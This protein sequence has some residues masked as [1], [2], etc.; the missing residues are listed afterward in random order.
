MSD[1][2]ILSLD[3][4]RENNT[5]LK[6]IKDYFQLSVFESNKIIDSFNL[7]I[8]A[9]KRG[10]Y[11]VAETDYVDKVYRDSYYHY[12]ATKL[13]EYHRNCIRIS[14]FCEE[15]I[16]N[17]L[18]ESNDRLNDIYRGFMVIRPL[19]D[20]PIGRTLISPLA[21]LDRDMAICSTYVNATVFGR[22]LR[23]LGFPHSSQ[24][25][26]TMTCAQVAIWSL[27]EYSGNKYSEYT[28]TLPSQIN[29]ILN[30]R[31]TI[32]QLPSVGLLLD[33][34]SIAIQKQGFGAITYS[35]DA[36]K[37]DF[38]KI[39]TCYVESGI[40][41]VVAL[42]NKDVKHAVLCIG[43]SS[44]PNT[45]FSK[46]YLD[47]VRFKEWNKNVDNF[48]FCDDN[49]PAYHK[50]LFKKPMN[51]YQSDSFANCQISHI[52]VPLYHKVYLEAHSAIKIQIAIYLQQLRLMMTQ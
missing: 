15:I 31:A 4:Q 2:F 37:E 38:K 22:K 43:R 30:F 8:S 5:L 29:K 10:L 46:T 49:L 47:G 6:I 45:K 44:K 32:R 25:T 24:D 17:T 50:A 35:Q 34:I 7:Y 9:L 3:D 28:P 19:I 33:D 48:I 52:V 12:Y 36:Y 41:I 26:E 18:F 39:F 42:E 14:F 51:G 27:M 40:P 23:V 20:S 16:E 21:M 1:I 13:D 11:I